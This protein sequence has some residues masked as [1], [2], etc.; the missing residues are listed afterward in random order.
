MSVSPPRP[1]GPP[2]N[3]L[4]AFEAAA[5]L[6]SFSAAAEELSVTPGAVSQHIKALEQWT[7]TPLFDR[8]AKGV[9]LSAAGRALLPQFV[10]AFDQLGL[11]ARALQ[12]IRPKSEIHIATLPSLAQIWL[13]PRLADVR[14][15]LPDVRL[16]VTALEAAPNLNRELFDIAIFIREPTGSGTETVISDDRIFPVCSPDLAEEVT[17][18]EDL[19]KVPLIYDRSW[20]DDWRLWV[21]Q[22]GAD[23]DPVPD[24]PS[25]S[26]YSLALEEAKSGAGVLIGHECLV[27]PALRARQLVRPFSE[28]GVTGKSLVVE[29]PQA[30]ADRNPVNTLIAALAK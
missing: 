1:K 16:S 19:R 22:A 7:S 14:S 29:V 11:A 23:I 17:S 28:I 10:S 2:L 5:R 26:L 15:K 27:G 18:H 6:G 12:D 3:A 9:R 25:Y 24:G 20:Q 30:A 4:R 8:G 21:A 13:P